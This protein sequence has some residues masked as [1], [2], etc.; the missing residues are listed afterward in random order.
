MEKIKFTKGELKKQ[1]DG[2]KQFKRYLPTLL[3]KKQQLQMKV[4]EVRRLLAEKQELLAR[5]ET[6]F[7]IWIG[8]LAD[9]QLPN[10]D[11]SSWV[12]PTAVETDTINIAGATLPVLTNVCFGEV[13]YDYYTMPFWLDLAVIELREYFKIVAQRHVLQQ[14]L[15]CLDQELRTTTQRVNLFEKVKIPQSQEYIR[16]IRIYLGDQM[17][18]AVGISKVAKSKILQ[19]AY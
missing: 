15:M 4:F 19:A 11:L 6:R 13:D 18:N 3:L 9:P 2:L 7:D 1:R 12:I 5:M 10:V 16:K 17:T 8:L 14:Q